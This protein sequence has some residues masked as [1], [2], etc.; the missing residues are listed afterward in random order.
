MKVSDLI[1]QLQELQQEHGDID[2]RINAEH[3]QC[4]MRTTW[5]GESYIEDGSWIAEGIH[6]DDLGEYQTLLRLQ[7]FR[8]IDVNKQRAKEILEEGGVLLYEG[9]WVFNR[10]Y[11]E[12]LHNEIGHGECCYDTFKS[13]EDAVEYLDDFCDGNYLEVEEI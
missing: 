5:V 11:M 9:T 1:R 2:V 4:L 7:R 3:S 6:E 12:C 13:L 10:Y 8:G